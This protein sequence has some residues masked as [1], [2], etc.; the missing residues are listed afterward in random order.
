M[1]AYLCDNIFSASKI[2]K[3]IE[4]TKARV[5][6]RITADSVDLVIRETI[7]LKPLFSPP[8]NWGSA[9]YEV[10]QDE[11]KWY[12]CIEISSDLYCKG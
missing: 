9:S 4:E 10:Y 11:G 12:A 1:G 7:W 3:G 8:K 6:S 2:K 5:S